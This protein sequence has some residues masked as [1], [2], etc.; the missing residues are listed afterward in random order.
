MRTIEQIKKTV[1]RGALR[2]LTKE[3]WD[4]VKD[5][6][7]PDGRS[8][9]SVV[10][11]GFYSWVPFAG[12]DPE[13]DPVYDLKYALSREEVELYFESVTTEAQAEGK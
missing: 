6:K 12:Y 13:G 7:H 4:K 3:W 8:V 5:L 10:F 11:D 2:L 1:N 9:K